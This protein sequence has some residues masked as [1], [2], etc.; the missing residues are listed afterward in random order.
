[1]RVE[2][3]MRVQTA[4]R[5]ETAVRAVRAVVVECYITEVLGLLGEGQ[6]D[7][8]LMQANSTGCRQTDRQT[9]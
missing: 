3:A 1:V 7:K 4:A 5:A 9:G 8:S 2:T 6:A